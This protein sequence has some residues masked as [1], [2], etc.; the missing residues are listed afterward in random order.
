MVRTSK[1]R[2][3][4][5]STYRGRS[6]EVVGQTTVSPLCVRPFEADVQAAAL[7]GSCRRAAMGAVYANM[8]TRAVGDP[9]GGTPPRPATRRVTKIGRPPLA[10]VSEASPFFSFSAKSIEIRFVCHYFYSDC[11]ITKGDTQ[12]CF[13][14]NT[15]G[16]ASRGKPQLSL[17][18]A[19]RT[20]FRVVSVI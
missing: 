15:D 4:C 19:H 7:G 16:G 10:L 17:C 5:E 18:Y 11:T 12:S 8:A 14:K 2:W 6:L 9:E 13:N 20:G 3:P 1:S